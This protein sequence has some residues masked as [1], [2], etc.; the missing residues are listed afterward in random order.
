[1]SV[2]LALELHYHLLKESYIL[3]Y[4]L[5]TFDHTAE[6]FWKLLNFW[7]VITYIKNPF[8]SNKKRMWIISNE[9]QI[10]V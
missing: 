5:A 9:T 3:K 7:V 6:M 4:F 1:M 10:I 2:G 8:I